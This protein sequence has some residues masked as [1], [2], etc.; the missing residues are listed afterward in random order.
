MED[1][2]LEEEIQKLVDGYFTVKSI[3]NINHDPHPFMLGPK[4][5]RFASNKY[6]GMLGDA[7]INDKNFP[8]CSYPGCNLRYQD[9]KSDRVLAL[10]LVKDITNDDGSRILKSLPL[11][12]NKIDGIIFVETDE[13]F[14]IT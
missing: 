7:C 2:K 1:K 4:H 6:M 9:H 3:M 13:K 10:S 14:R 11:L 12:E 8:T 5:I